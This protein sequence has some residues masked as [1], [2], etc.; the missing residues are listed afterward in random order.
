MVWEK[1]KEYLF[2]IFLWVIVAWLLTLAILYILVDFNYWSTY[3]ELF[4]TIMN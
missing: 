1:L 3:S 2:I 4:T